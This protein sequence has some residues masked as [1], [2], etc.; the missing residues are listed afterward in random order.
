MFWLG[1][2]LVALMGLALGLLG[3]GGSILA[4]PILEY[5]FGMEA[6]AAIAG[7][8]VL[9]GSTAL[10]SALLHHRTTPVD[11]RGAL[12]FAAIGAPLS[13]AGGWFSRRVPGSVLMLLFGLLMLVVGA[14]ILRERR[15]PPPDAKPHALA[16]ALSGAAVGF[17]TGFLGI[18]GGFLIVPALVL[19]LYVPMKRA[20]GTSLLV[21]A[22]NARASACGFASGGG[23]RCPRKIAAPTTSISS[24]N[25]SISTLPGMRREN[26]PPARLSGAPM[27]AKTSAPRQSTGVVRWCSSAESSA[28]L[29]TSTSEPAIAACGSI[30][31]TYSRMGTARIEPPPPSSPSASPISAI[32]TMPSQNMP[33]V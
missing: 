12:V 18:G 10:L 5:V 16:L 3:G 6:H 32:S 31:K 14:A 20:V 15:E 2:V 30:P 1:I 22:L 25:R 17:L 24:P 28:A 23:S 27:A 19:F 11:W 7:S 9:V 21:I 8:L 26:H 29:P 13:L 33:G 4:V